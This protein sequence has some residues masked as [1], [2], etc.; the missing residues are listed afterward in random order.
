[1]LSLTNLRVAILITSRFI[2]IRAGSGIGIEG[3]KT[4][5]RNRKRDVENGAYCDVFFVVKGFKQSI[6]G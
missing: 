4:G 3:N 5:G 6:A 1:M 2:I